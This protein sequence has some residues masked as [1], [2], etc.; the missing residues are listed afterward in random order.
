MGVPSLIRVAIALV[1]FAPCGLSQVNFEW[2]DKFAGPGLFSYATAMTEHD[3]G[4]GPEICAAVDVGSIGQRVVRFN[5]QAWTPMP[6]IFNERVTRLTSVS[7]GP[8]AGLYACGHFEYVDTTQIGTIARWNGAQWV[9]LGTQFI[10]QNYD[11]TA[12]TVFDLGNGPRV[13]V[14]VSG[15]VG[16]NGIYAW[17][18]TAWTGVPNSAGPISW[19]VQDVI[20]FDFGA[21]P[22]LCIAADQGIARWTGSA[23]EVIASGGTVRRLAGF[24][25]GSGARLYAGGDFTQLNGAA[26]SY[27]AKFNGSAWSQ[28]GAGLG[29][30][31]QRG[32]PI[33]TDLVA[34]QGAN[35]RLFVCGS[36]THAGGF[37]YGP[38]AAWTG[39]TWLPTAQYFSQEGGNPLL[40]VMLL[41]GPPGAERLY[42]AGSFTKVN[43]MACWNVARLPLASGVWERVPSGNGVQPIQYNSTIRASAVFDGGNGPE[44]VVAGNFDSIGGTFF[45]N[46]A[47]WNG[48]EWLPLGTGIDGGTGAFGSPDVYALEVWD[49]GT[50]PALFVGGDFGSAGGVPCL[51]I[52]KWNGTSWSSVGNGLNARVWTLKGVQAPYPVL[53]AGGQFT[54]SPATSLVVAGIA[55]W[56]GSAWSQFPGYPVASIVRAVAGFDSGTGLDLY[57]GTTG[58]F[59]GGIPDGGIQRFNGVTWSL[60]PG[61]GSATNVNALEVFDDGMGSALYAGCQNGAPHLRKVTASGTTGVAS[62]VPSGFNAIT[63]LRVFDDGDGPGLYVGGSYS[64]IAGSTIAALSRYR[65]GTFAQLGGGLQKLGFHPAYAPSLVV[66]SIT[67]H[68]DGSGPALFAFGNCTH[69]GPFGSNSIAKWGAGPPVLDLAQPGGAGQ[70]AFLYLSNLQ[71]GRE[72]FDIASFESCG[73]GPGT[74]PYLGLCASNPT[75]LV[76]QA[77]SPVGT[78]PF[79]FIATATM[80]TFGPYAVPPGLTC[81]AIC[82]DATA[83]HLWRV[84]AVDSILTQ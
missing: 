66:F 13:V 18:G 63:S 47:R 53:V 58:G 52:A 37:G 45:N 32:M 51:N 83:N 57:L 21:G 30:S 34:V 40:N 42:A 31:I 73:G 16:L 70:P 75:V 84:S 74:G 33:V 67:V 29:L 17:D 43:G 64:S 72:Y 1:L 25:D 82:I 3:F 23:W 12:M 77:L 71:A 56:S 6:P 14:V 60:V 22:R 8:L 59:V 5:G 69:A 28:V 9:S 78:E 36:F 24:D 80:K 46:I 49:D 79:H 7:S 35:P 15:S 55:V 54:G 65:G 2:S 50:G 41:T 81:E 48:S 39:S 68:D 10:G 4:A 19:Q 26:T 61:W 38:L 27:L 76:N 20:S 62:T 11:L 44:L